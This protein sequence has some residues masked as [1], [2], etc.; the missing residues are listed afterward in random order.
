[1]SCELGFGEQ[2]ALE[3][4]EEQSV[5]DGAVLRTVLYK[6]TQLPLRCCVCSVCVRCVCV[7]EDCW[8]EERGFSLIPQT[9]NDGQEV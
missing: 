7:C 4:D 1:M 2:C 9:L 5:C 8:S 3:E 6:E